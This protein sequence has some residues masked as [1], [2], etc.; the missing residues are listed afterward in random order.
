MKKKIVSIIGVLC[1]SNSLMAGSLQIANNSF[2]CACAVN[3]SNAFKGFQKHVT[4]ENLEPFYD[5]LKLNIDEIN[6]NIEKEKEKGIEI[7]KSN[8]L[9]VEKIATVSNLLFEL[10]KNLNMLKEN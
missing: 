4:T 2:S 1:L 8:T 3:L 9:Y 5:N 10:K 7:D 6:K